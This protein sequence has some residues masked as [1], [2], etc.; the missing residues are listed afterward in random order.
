MVVARIVRVYKTP[1]GKEPF[2]E[3]AESLSEDYRARISKRIGLI[4]QS[5][6]GDSKFI[7]EGVHELRLVFGPGFRIYYG[8]DGTQL[9]LLLCGGDKS[10]QS[11]DIEKAKRYWKAYKEQKYGKI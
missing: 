8:I 11:K 2:T 3:W 1:S 9:I 5:H 4:N 7:G 6:F 10:S